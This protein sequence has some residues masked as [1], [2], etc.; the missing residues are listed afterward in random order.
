MKKNK[1]AKTPV[2]LQMEN[3]ECGAA[4]LAMVLAYYGRWVPLEKLRVDC[5]VSRDGSNAK[6]MVRAARNYGLK[7]NGYRMEL[8]ELKSEPD[9]P[10]V[11]FW[12]YNHFIVLNGIK[13]GRF[14][15][16]DPARGNLR[17]EEEEFAEG[18]TGIVINML[19]GEDFEPGGEKKSITK[20]ISIRSRGIKKAIVFVVLTT[21]VA[22][23]FDAVNP[24]MTAV[25]LNDILGGTQPGW[26]E[27]FFYILA[28]FTILSI[29]TEWIRAIYTL[30]INGRMSVMG[31]VY[32]M[33][34]M[35]RLPMSFFSQR[36]AG[37]IMDRQEMNAQIAETFI[38]NVAPLVLDSFMM[39]I[40]LVI[41]L[42][43][44]IYLSLIGVFGIFLHILMARIISNSR[45]NITRVQVRDEGRLHSYTLS[46]M[47]MIET[48]KS[49]GAESGFFGK[50]SGYQSAVY[51]SRSR[52]VKKDAYLNI[53]PNMIHEISEDIVLIAGVYLV[54]HGEIALGAI[55]S[56]QEIIAL[57]M[58]PAV[59]TIAS[60]QAIREMTMQM[61]RVEDVMNYPEDEVFARSGASDTLPDTKYEKLKGNISIKNLTFGYGIKDKPLIKD[62]SFDIKAGEKIAIVGESGCGKSTIAGLLS[63]LYSPWEGEILF[64]GIPIEKIDR[65]VLTGSLAVVDQDIILFEDTFAA[66]IK[67]WDS[68]IEDFEMILA[69]RDA[70]LHDEIMAREGA[71]QGMIAEGGKNLS[72]GERQRVEIARVLAEDP[73][74]VILDEATSALDSKTEAEVV[75]AICAR[76]ITC[77]VIAHR[78]STVKDSDEIF[79]MDHGKIVEKGTHDELF[80]MNG[81]YKELVVGE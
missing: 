33:W 23:F 50:W 15:I 65:R 32:Y 26:V 45:I 46:G 80:A 20:F 2:I 52:Y 78:L 1:V 43:E 68:A 53:I 29:I 66:N 7:A 39:I 10:C 34:H 9:F 63:G 31:S 35:F 11:V 14:Y 36:M 4:C 56:F 57:F 42:R 54:I 30:R 28:L 73:S 72:G 48:I 77:I 71:Y 37:D 74:I 69:A 41:M 58:R 59:S 40:Y 22:Y 67:M 47:H 61:E 60:S 21:F 19:P 79:V 16:N 38:R 62:I 12:E 55:L 76:G 81:I 49:C 3:L 51:E 8:D 64:D 13:N 27:P 5:G 18:F 25:F 6:N 75:K 70:D 17:M 44:H 24:G